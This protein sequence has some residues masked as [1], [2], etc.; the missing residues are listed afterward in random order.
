MS[1]SKKRK[2]QF[3]TISFCVYGA[4]VFDSVLYELLPNVSLFLIETL[5]VLAE[6]WKFKEYRCESDMPHS[7][8]FL[9]IR[10]LLELST[11]V[12]LKVKI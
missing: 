12:P 5:S 4:Y 1:Q 8:F 3:L 7:F 11:T 10:G 6:Y 9:L 2:I